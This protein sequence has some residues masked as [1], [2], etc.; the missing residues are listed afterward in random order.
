MYSEMESPQWYEDSFFS[1]SSHLDILPDDDSDTKEIKNVS[2]TLMLFINS[3]QLEMSVYITLKIIKMM[4]S[5]IDKV[6]KWDKEYGWS[7]GVKK[8][9]IKRRIEIDP[10][11]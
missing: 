10:H 1:T 7:T 9:M 2:Y 11:V 3:E 5:M 8:G 4:E 6:C